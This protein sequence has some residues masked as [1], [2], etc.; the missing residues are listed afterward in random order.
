MT[1]RVSVFAEDESGLAS[2]A[3]A[4]VGHDADVVAR[5]QVDGEPA[6]ITQQLKAWIA[7]AGVDVV[8]G[9]LTAHSRAALRPL[10]TK[11]L[12]SFSELRE[13]EGGRCAATVVV[14]VPP[15]RDAAN[16]TVAKVFPKIEHELFHKSGPVVSPVAVISLPGPLPKTPPPVPG[17]AKTAPIAPPSGRTPASGIPTVGASP[18]RTPPTGVP[19]LPPVVPGSGPVSAGPPRPPPRTREPTIPVEQDPGAILSEEPSS[20]AAVVPIASAPTPV[21]PVPSASLVTTPPPARGY[22]RWIALAG[23][24]LVG[25]GAAAFALRGK[26][27]PAS[28]AKHVE[29][30]VAAPEPVPEADAAVAEPAPDIEMPDDVAASKP[31]PGRSVRAH[32]TTP[33]V[34]RVAEAPPAHAATAA[35]RTHVEAVAED[36]CD[37]VSCVVDNF[38]RACCAPFK[39][40]KPDETPYALDKPMI[41]AG[42]GKAKAAVIRCGE[43]HA[44]AKG[45]VKIAMVV[46]ADGHVGTATVAASPDPAL[47]ECVASAV[48]KATFAATETGGSFTYP[49]KF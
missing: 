32:T 31:Q 41:T 19:V 18:P 21:V 7:D 13:V 5:V 4:L 44:A 42:I 12:I 25:G 30:A 29:T 33:A 45:I 24:V 39:P 48:R 28:V 27:A 22:G 10:I 1:L 14:L 49:F 35:S 2:L 40:R 3:R 37:K 9:P 6:A 15:G 20:P 8:V 23:L 43:Q 38:A 46:G 36:G 16:D 17:R 34:R 11:R 47:G 26:S